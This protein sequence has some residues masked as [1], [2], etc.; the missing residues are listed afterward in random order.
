MKVLQ[1]L[2]R[3]S[4]DVSLS[5][6]DK[7]C[8]LL[9]LG[10]ELLAMD[11]G[12]VSAINGQDYH[13]ISASSPDN[14]IQPGDQFLLGDTFC[15]DTLQADGIVAYY[16]ANS[17]HPCYQAFGLKAYI[18]IPITVNNERHG[19][20]NFSSP[21]P[22][23]SD[24]S[25]TEKYY[26]M[27]FA[28]WTG[29][30]ISRKLTL[31]TLISQQEEL[32]L[33]A[34]RLEQMAELAGVGT[35][36][37]DVEKLTLS[38]SPSLQKILEIPEDFGT[39]LDNSFSLIPSAY[40]KQ[41]LSDLLHRCIENGTP[42]AADIEVR[43]PN[44]NQLWIATQA[45]QELDKNKHKRVLGATQNI[46]ARIQANLELDRRRKVA[47]EALQTRSMFLANMS[48][49]IRTPI[50]GVL[51]MLEAL[52]KT[53]LSTK[54]QEYTN[55]AKH[56]ANTL[57]ELVN[58][59][60]DFSK[61][62]S[63]QITFEDAPIGISSL[64][65]QLCRGFSHQAEQKGLNFHLDVS[66]TDKLVLFGDPSRIKQ[67]LTNLINNAIKFTQKG[68]ISV[69]TKALLQSD[70]LYLLKLIVSDSGVGIEKSRQTEIF[71]PFKQADSST[72]RQYGGTGL[73]LAIVAQITKQLKGKIKVVSKIGEG[74]S[75]VVSIPMATVD[76]SVKLPQSTAEHQFAHNTRNIFTGR[77]ILV[78][79]DNE[80]NQ[81]VIK[82][83]LTDMGISS[84]IA[85]NGSE[86][87]KRITERVLTDKQYE[88][89]LMDCQMPI[90]DGYETATLIRQLGGIAEK[91]PI[92]AIT[93]NALAGEREKC[94]LAGMNDYLTKPLDSQR[95]AVCLSQYF[96]TDTHLDGSGI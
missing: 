39:S 17:S 87:L 19:T 81:L 88:L 23:N 54:Q 90:M 9:Q 48:H 89:I 95:I 37:L 31:D 25:E 8:R 96:L 84:D 73:G 92:V 2:K 18:G 72:T 83:Q 52:N 68:T 78:V 74:S 79:E 29:T 30:E 22:R 28:E 10:R 44:G 33:Q 41:R 80:I 51:G 76:A 1:Q 16:Q 14:S 15:K 34:L 27:L 46:T 47:E 64:T 6:E 36:E 86:A 85:N 53:A 70:G 43:T 67:I 13:V 94:L 3:V 45:R 38:L 42:F 24:F 20:L 32:H 35:W 50:N 5:F 21:E 71:S 4:S 66:G 56:S 82:E 58:D 12:I 69:K 49:E 63:G 93:A 60:L 75:F 62:D 77:H 57:L 55:I 11:I 59:I 65:S 40:E 91:I 26:L 61:I 7:L